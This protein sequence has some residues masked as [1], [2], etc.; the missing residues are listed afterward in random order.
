[1]YSSMQD[2]MLIG[3]QTP[4][5]RSFNRMCVLK[6]KYVQNAGLPRHFLF[7][8]GFFGFIISLGAMTIQIKFP[9]F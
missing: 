9:F 5:I 6:G 8:I 2:R 1:M 4:T 3:L 7:G